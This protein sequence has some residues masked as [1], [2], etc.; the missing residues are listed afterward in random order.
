[1]QWLNNPFVFPILIAGMISVV[2]ALV[3]AQRRRVT[4]SLPLLGM[5]IA[6]GWWAF[7]YSFELASAQQSWELFWSK[8][9][10]IGIVNVPVFF[11]LFAL[12]YSGYRPKIQKWMAWFWIIPLITLIL[13]WTNDFHGLIWSHI[14]Q[15]V[16][17]GYNLLAVDHGAAFWIWAAYSYLCLAAGLIILMIRAISS[18]PEFRL[19]AGIIALGALV[20]VTGNV[21]YL[22][23]LIPVPDLDVTPISFALAMLIYSVGLFRFGILDIMRIASETVLES[24]DEVVIVLNNQ[25]FIVFINNVFDY[26]FGVDPKNLIGKF[27]D[28]VFA[29]WPELKAVSAQSSAKRDEIDLNLPN[30]GVVFFDITISKIRGTNNRELGRTIILD[31]VTE[32]RHA[33][34]R[35]TGEALGATVDIPLIIVY[36][37]NDERIVEVNR[38]VLLKLGYERRDIVGRTLLELGI[39]DAYQRTDFLRALNREGSLR[40]FALQFMGQAGKLAPYKFFA[41]QN[42]IQGERYVVLMAQEAK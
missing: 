3:V 27:A 22:A 13:V 36:R 30:F 31:D 41:N 42:E 7:T 35:M 24:M 33:E 16:S 25:G 23:K 20:S 26:Y 40:D 14:S 2:N 28:E 19:Q 4:G 6:V 32:R 5:M 1:M 9:E 17:G 11:L 37:A 10:Y 18:L 12:E 15:Q 39:W 29:A 38:S 8:M 21:L 34:K